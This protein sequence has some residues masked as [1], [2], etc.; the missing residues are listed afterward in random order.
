HIDQRLAAMEAG[1]ARQA[2][3]V[4][5]TA[6]LN[7]LAEGARA[8]AWQVARKTPDYNDAYHH[9]VPA[10]DAE[11]AAFG[12]PPAMR[13]H[14]I[15]QEEL[16]IAAQS[17]AAGR[18]PAETLYT[19]AKARGF[20]PKAGDEGGSGDAAEAQIDRIERGQARGR[21]L[22]VAGGGAGGAEM[23]ASKLLAMSN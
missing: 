23:T 21:T 22:S 8:E 15:P 17:F 1:N 5:E 6:E 19:L 14:P 18:S 3:E 16:Q 11:L 20:R 9:F 7:Q 10:R 2:A 4:A 13:A 12:Y